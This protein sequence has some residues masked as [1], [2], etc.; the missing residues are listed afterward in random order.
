M[1][2]AYCYLLRN[3]LL[4][5]YGWR[6][7]RESSLH[8]KRIETSKRKLTPH[9]IYSPEPMVNIANFHFCVISLEM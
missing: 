9:Y 5:Y 1:K 2:K 7:Q 8:T 4:A 6:L 3:T